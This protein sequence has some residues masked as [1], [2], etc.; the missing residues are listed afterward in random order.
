M[1]NGEASVHLDRT[2][3]TLEIDEA[4]TGPDL[5]RSLWIPYYLPQWSSPE[6]SAAR[7]QVA[8]GRL[9]LEIGAD[10]PPWC[11]EYDGWLRVSSLQTGAFSGPVGSAI[12]QH[13][14]RD[15]MVV[16]SA[17]PPRALYTPT[18]GLFEARL[19]ALDDPANMVALWMIGSEDEPEH[20]G[21]ILI[22]EIFGRDVTPGSAAVGMGIR[23]HHDPFLTDAF[24]QERLQIDARAFHD[25][26]AA[27]APDHVAFYVDERLVK[28]VPQSPAYPMQFLL[29][30]YEFADGPEPPSPRARYPKVFEV[31]WF[32]GWRRAG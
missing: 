14:F 29:G 24:S 32:R 20:S 27:W 22:A 17:Q 10:Q 11:P 8:D 9:R 3:Y 25:Y 5:N 31:D 12:G 23:R 2:G 21:E 26:A 13:R 6:A 16:R 4:F 7:Y 1:G 18:F 30:I 19:R 28:L 15:G